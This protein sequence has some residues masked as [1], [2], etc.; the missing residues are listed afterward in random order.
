MLGYSPAGGGF[1]AGNHKN[2]VSGGR[3]DKSVSPALSLFA[4]QN[5]H[6]ASILTEIDLPG[7][8]VLGTVSEACNRSSNRE[9]TGSGC[10][11]W[12]QWSR[13]GVKMD[14]LP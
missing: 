12:S 3:F 7:C 10:Q 4:S 13:C 5:S 8:C 14:C 6:V 1:F 11:A 2:D 9:R